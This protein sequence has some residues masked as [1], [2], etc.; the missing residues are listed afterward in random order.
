M[1]QNLSL[2]KIT[3]IIVIT[4]LVVSGATYALMLQQNN[5]LNERII[6]LEENKSSEQISEN[7]EDLNLFTELENR[8]AELEKN[9]VSSSSTV[10]E[11]V[12]ISQDIIDMACY[13]LMG[14]KD[15]LSDSDEELRHQLVNKYCKR[16]LY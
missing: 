15:G 1:Q 13:G 4:G 7:S 9:T 14:E 6:S 2:I 8:I 3:L 16:F 5:L 12:N 11:N 10:Q